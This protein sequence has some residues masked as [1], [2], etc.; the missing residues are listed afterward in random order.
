MLVKNSGV[1][2]MYK[3]YIIGTGYLSS[4]L[5]KKIKNAEI[6]SAQKFILRL[7]SLNKDKKK[8][9][10]IINSFYSARK[11]SNLTSYKLFV[12]KSL[13]QISEI[14]DSLNPKLI[15]KII[16]TSSSSVYGSIGGKAN[17]IDKNNRYI[18]SSLKISA[19]NL[20]KNFS[21]KNKINFDIC[22]VFNLYGV[23]DNFSI[24]SKLL[25]CKK[26]KSN[27]KIYNDGAS[28]RDFIHVDDV[29]QIYI[30]LLNLKESNIFDI[31]TGKG[32]KIKDILINL[33]LSNKKIKFVKEK[34]LKLIALLPTIQT[35]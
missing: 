15:N 6:V 9:N 28:I 4:K 33:N 11:L 34:T 25:E 10:L 5:I 14:F 2:L 27:I 20:V 7:D 12:E 8:F 17:I 13:F 3:T 29:V 31:G 16:Y 35:F 19:E 30:K 24:I 23:K 18:Y 32:I 26:T 22:R 1:L 21:N